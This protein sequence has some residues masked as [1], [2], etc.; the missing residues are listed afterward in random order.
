MFSSCD[1]CM[2]LLGTLLPP[3]LFMTAPAVEAVGEIVSALF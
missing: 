3:N 1:S 2:I